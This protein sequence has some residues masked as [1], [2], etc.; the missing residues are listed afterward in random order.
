MHHAAYQFVPCLVM[1]SETT[2]A[3]QTN[4]AGQKL[5]ALY[6]STYNIKPSKKMVWNVP[7][8][9]KTSL[10]QLLGNVS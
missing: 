7:Q 8:V 6:G 3:F 2:Y 5:G 10:S 4:S 9:E 1:A